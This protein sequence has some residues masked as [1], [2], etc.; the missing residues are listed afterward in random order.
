MQGSTVFTTL[1][2]KNGYHQLPV[3]PSDIEKTAFT[4]H[5]GQFEFL[6]VPFGLCNAPSHFQRVMETIL[7]VCVLV[8]IDDLVIYSPNM[9]SHINHDKVVLQRIR[10]ANLRLKPSKCYFAKKQVKLLGYTVSQSGFKPDPDKTAAI[11]ALSPPTT[12]KQV[13]SFLGMANYYR[14]CIPNYANIASPLTTLTRKN[15]HF[16]WTPLHDKSFQELKQI[17]TSPTVVSFPRTELPYT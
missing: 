11:Q 9:E 10:K 4:C 2:L 6:R 15:Q 8:Y 17:L 7:G 3:H 16:H 12:V 13:R 1:D 14:N 5:R